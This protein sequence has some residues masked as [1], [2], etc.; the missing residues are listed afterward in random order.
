M[1]TRGSGFNAAVYDVHEGRE[2]YQRTK[3]SIFVKAYPTDGKVCA[4]CRRK[5]MGARIKK[6]GDGMP[7]ALCL[8]HFW[9]KL[10]LKGQKY[11][12]STGDRLFSEA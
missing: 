7:A 5:W 1:R 8:I 11:L 12:S 6:I 2:D 4:D 3:R 10:K 9:G